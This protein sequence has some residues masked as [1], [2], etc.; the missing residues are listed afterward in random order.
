MQQSLFILLFGVMLA[1]PCAAV[2]QFVWLTDSSTHQD[3]KQYRQAL[4]VNGLTLKLL[5]QDVTDFQAQPLQATTD[6]AM[7]MLKTEASA[8]A[9]NKVKNDKRLTFSYAT[10][11]PHTVFPGLR[12]YSKTNTQ[13]TIWLQQQLNKNNKINL[14]QLLADGAVTLRGQPCDK[15]ARR[16]AVGDNL[17]VWLRPTPQAQAF[18]ALRRLQLDEQHRVQRAAWQGRRDDPRH[19]EARVGAR[20]PAPVPP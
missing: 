18:V 7:A 1:S 8:C 2:Q 14:Q 17:G 3:L 15:A 20:N 12:L 13:T 9:G 19:D 11:I 16:V 5:M 4:D 6:R 10:S